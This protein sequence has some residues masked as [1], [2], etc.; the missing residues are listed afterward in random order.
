[1]EVDF[2]RLFPTLREQI[3]GLREFSTNPAQRIRTGFHRVDD[4]C[5]G[6]APGEVF[7]VIGRSFTGKSLLGQNIVVNNPGVPSIFFSL[8]MPYITALQRMY[9]MWSGTPHKD[10]QQMTEAG[11]LPHHLD[12]M[13]DLFHNH[14]IVDKEALSLSFMSMF[15]DMFTQQH[16]AR[17]EFVVIDY[18]ELLGGTKGKAEGWVGTEAQAASLKDWAKKEEMRVFVLHQTNKQE[19]PWKPPTENSARGA[20]YT[21]ADFVVGI[22]QKWRDP[23]MTYLDQLAEKDKLRLN[24][25]KNRAYG[26]VTGHKELLYRVEPSLRITDIGYADLD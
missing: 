6:P 19:N 23:E 21:E 25:L 1:M 5:G 3:E 18:L 22:W 17:P 7:M 11:S 14:R 15:C 12:S 8:E 16:D 24:V 26:D 13:A 4:L 2:L 20:G 9:S 10:T